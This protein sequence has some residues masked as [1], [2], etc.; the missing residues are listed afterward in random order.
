MIIDFYTG[1]IVNAAKAK[2]N[3]STGFESIENNDVYAVAEDGRINVYGRYDKIEVFNLNGMNVANEGLENG[4]YI[5]RITV[6][7][8]VLVRKVIVR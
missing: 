7:N 4:I 3:S 2:L 6:G 8:N 5:A 1:E